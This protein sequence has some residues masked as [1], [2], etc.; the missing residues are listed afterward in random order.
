MA[1]L[2]DDDAQ[3]SSHLSL[4]ER[5]L[6]C[7]APLS[8][9]IPGLWR[10]DR[11]DL[12]LSAAL[13]GSILVAWVLSLASGS[14][15]TLFGYWDG[16][17]YVYIARTWYSI[18]GDNPWTISLRYPPS[19][20]ACHFPG[21]PLVIRLFTFLTFGCY[22]TGDLLAILF[23]SLASLFV[24]RR[25]LIV[26]NATKYV[27]ETCLLFIFLPVRFVIYRSVG[28]SEPLYV[29]YCYLALICYR[30]NNFFLLL[31]ALL[32][33]SMT[34]IEGVSIVGTIGLCYLLRLHFFG[35]FVTA[36]SLVA[37]A[38]IFCMHKWKFGNWL[39]YF[40]FN[41]QGM[42]LLKL[43][44][45]HKVVSLAKCGEL[46]H[47]MP[48]VYLLSVFGTG[49]IVVMKVAFPL[50]IFATVYFFFCAVITHIDV[51]RYS[52][53]GLVLVVLIEFDAIWGSKQF[54]TNW[55]MLA[56][57]YALVVALYVTGNLA[58]NR[59]TD[60]WVRAVMNPEKW[61]Y[62]GGPWR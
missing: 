10:F 19:Y 4:L 16:P 12:E 61:P 59:A 21:F 35:V 42:G 14:V 22:W 32:G 11:T 33:A 55:Y 6:P 60:E 50:G 52:L 28:A 29:S 43:P 7:L 53:P 9:P 62:K 46:V 31:P 48:T 24:F 39:A 47:S 2:I 57:P 56:T 34:R 3:D 44:P 45:F 13:L 49:L 17:N 25:L 15:F 30:T 27:R 5:A 1:V 23:C 38:L 51:W 37:P 36:L 8:D 40:A 20:F 18:P 54:R 26:Y 41:Q 58:S